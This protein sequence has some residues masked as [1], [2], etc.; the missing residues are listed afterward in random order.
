VRSPLPDR[1]SV[2]VGEVLKERYLAFHDGQRGGG[3]EVAKTRHC[4]T[5]GDDSDTVALDGQ[6]GNVFWMFCQRLR[7]AAYAWCIGHG[8]VVSRAQSD[9]GRD[10]DL[11]AEVY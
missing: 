4:G 5:V 9:L 1:P 2:D 3:A 7:D 8:Q 10:G 6:F 11:S